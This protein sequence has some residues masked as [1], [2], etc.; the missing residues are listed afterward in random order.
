M[1]GYPQIIIPKL[2]QSI[3]SFLA[4][5]LAQKYIL[6]VS[7]SSCLSVPE[8]NVDVVCVSEP[9][10]IFTRKKNE[11]YQILIAF[12]KRDRHTYNASVGGGGSGL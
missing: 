3:F 6:Q 8:R 9:Q 10:A 1:T 2:L 12:Q 7:K 11:L 5:A 4:A